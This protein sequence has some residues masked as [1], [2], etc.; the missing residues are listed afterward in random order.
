VIRLASLHEEASE[1]CLAFSNYLCVGKRQF[2]MRRFKR[3]RHSTASTKITLLLL[4]L[5]LQR[6]LSD[7]AWTVVLVVPSTTALR[8]RATCSSSSSKVAMLVG[9]PDT[10]QGVVPFCSR[11]PVVRVEER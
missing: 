9:D 7:D 5:L 10:G 1:N 8:A 11:T 4:P 2:S 6:R 3:T